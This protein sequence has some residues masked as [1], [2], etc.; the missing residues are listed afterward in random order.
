MAKNIICIFIKNEYNTLAQKT[1]SGLSSD[2]L[3]NGPLDA[4]VRFGGEWGGEW[5]GGERGGEWGRGGLKGSLR[6]AVL[7]LLQALWFPHPTV[8]Q[9][10]ATKPPHWSLCHS[11]M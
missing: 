9:D 3:R 11:Y 8:S 4:L 1:A 2:S 10:D 7:P 6:L 5:G